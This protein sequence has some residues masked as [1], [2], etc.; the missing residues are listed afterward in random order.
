MRAYPYQPTA[1]RLHPGVFSLNATQDLFKAIRYA[2][3]ADAPRLIEIA[4]ANGANI[5]ALDFYGFGVLEQAVFN[6]KIRVLKLLLAKGAILP[7]VEPNGY[8]LLM[9]AASKGHTEMA[10]ALIN[11]AGMSR[12][13]SDKNG[14]TALHYAVINQHLQ[15]AALL[16]EQG[17]DLNAKTKSMP[18]SE[19]NEI[20][21]DEHNLSGANITPFMIAVAQ[22][23]YDMVKLFF[24]KDENIQDGA[25][26]PLLLAL[27]N[28]DSQ[29]LNILL[30][31][32]VSTNFF[33]LPQNQTLIE[34]ALT[35][36]VNKNCLKIL[37]TI[38][39]IEKENTQHN[40]ALL[41]IAVKT[42]NYSAVSLFIEHGVKLNNVVPRSNIWQL[43]ADLPDAQKMLTLLAKSESGRWENITIGDEKNLLNL[44]CETEPSLAAYASIGILPLTAQKLLISLAQYR[45]HPKVLTNAQRIVET[46]Q[47]LEEI[48]TPSNS[49]LP[50]TDK[51]IRAKSMQ[52]EDSWIELSNAH[53]AEQITSLKK[54]GEIIRQNFLEQLQDHLTNEF[55]TSCDAESHD[56]NQV[57]HLIKTKLEARLGLPAIAAEI[58]A[59]GWKTAAQLIQS[60]NIVGSDNFNISEFKYQ[61]ARNLIAASIEKIMPV[62]DIF[63]QRSLHAIKQCIMKTGASLDTL[64]DNPIQALRNVEKRSNLQAVDIPS[65]KA[66]LCVKFGLPADLSEILAQ[67]WSGSVNEVRNSHNWHNPTQMHSALQ[68][69]LRLTLQNKIRALNNSQPADNSPLQSEIS[70]KLLQWCEA[71][72]T[73]RTE[74]PGKR[75]YRTDEG[76]SSPSKKPRIEN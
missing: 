33:N 61:L 43:A 28:N 52:S 40:Q 9:H 41:D 11:I 72:E 15:T 21:G 31:N 26:H 20:F 14:K 45:Q 54:L 25:Q 53:H 76:L 29:M 3:E 70:R 69:T 59:D 23:N 32:G 12:E 42:K 10:A 55:F 56:P 18:A 27:R 49:V 19:L 34:Y 64:C 71:D 60:S 8:D 24:S 65:L 38:F 66:A 51:L 35:N 46:A 48:A 2:D 1:Q 68:K 13:E 62:E 50:L 36:K 73:M 74:P 67:C 5:D 22:R 30:E 47:F 44:I 17:S 6:N 39:P 4:I 7:I 58:I 75:A 63:A 57:M 37:L 16:I